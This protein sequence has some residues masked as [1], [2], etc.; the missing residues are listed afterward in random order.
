MSLAVKR[1]PIYKTSVAVHGPAF[2]TVVHP[3][4]AR[5]EPKPALRRRAHEPP[6]RLAMAVLAVG[7]EP[8]HLVLVAELVEA[9]EL[10]ERV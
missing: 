9:D 3:K 6:H 7:G 1:R 5:T 4:V 8:H 10:A 2:A